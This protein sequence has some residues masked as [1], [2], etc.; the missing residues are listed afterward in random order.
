ML[1]NVV[2]AI[3]K[4]LE[5]IETSESTEEKKIYLFKQVE[6]YEGQLSAIEQFIIKP[7]A[8]FVALKRDTPI[9]EYDTSCH[10]IFN[11]IVITSHMKGKSKSSMFNIIDTLKSTFTR[12]SLTENSTSLGRCFYQGAEEDATLPG[13]CIYSITI[14]VEAF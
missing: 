4:V 3:I 1:D 9:D 12:L 11:L 13:M 6:P 5:E 14:K 8:V 10:D 2:N 7:P